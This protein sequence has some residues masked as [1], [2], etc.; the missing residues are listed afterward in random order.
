MTKI[1]I[2]QNRNRQLIGLAAGIAALAGTIVFANLLRAQEAPTPA[3]AAATGGRRARP[4]AQGAATPDFPEANARRG[5]TEKTMFPEVR[6][7]HEMVGGGNN[8]V[9]EAGL[10]ILHEGGNA[11]DAGVAATLAAAVTEE[12]HFSMGGEMPLLIKMKGQPVQVVS[13]VGTAPMKATPEFYK[14]RPLEPWETPD[15]KPVIPAQGILAT[16]TPGMFDGVMLALEKYGTMSYAQVAAPAIELADAFPTT[17]IFAS[18]LKNDESMLRRWP[19]SVSYF[20]INDKLPVPGQVFKQPDLAKTMRAMVAAE[21]SAKGDRVAKIDAVRDYFYRGPVAKKMGAYS[22]ANGGLETY[23]D[24]A[25]FHAEIDTPRSTTF[26]GYEIVKPGFWTQGPVLLEMF[27]LLESYDLKG[28]GHNSPEYLHTLVE[29]AKLAFADRDTYYGDPKFAKVPEELLLSKSYAADRRKL[30]DPAH[31]SMESRPGQIPGYDIHMPSGNVSKVVVNDTTCVDVVDKVG[32][33]YS[34]TPSGAWLPAD[35]VGDTGIAFGS[36][37]QS[38]VT[39]PGHPNL[40]Q[41]GKRPRVTL[42]PTL[43]LKDG[44]PFLAISTPGADNQ[45][46]A[47]LQVILNIIVFNMTPQAAVEAPRFQTDAFY[48]SFAMHEFVPGKLNLESR[49]PQATADKLTALGHIV[50]VTGP[51]T[52][53]SAPIA[54]KLDEDGVLEGGADPRR[55]RF[56]N[57]D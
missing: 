36:R 10:R 23:S 42:S 7:M 41:G 53:A 1:G 19:S 6:S 49:I 9:T 28:M 31:A 5:A 44:K 30:I 24:I 27:N 25:A 56:I 12:D 8:F 48:S 52:N 4:A 55:G 22:E 51:W 16:T 20:F 45:D 32:N 3:P 50:T 29:A 14:N 40:L 54:I 11:V 18:T 37:L 13:G 46:Q 17:E 21:Q 47:L 57:G 35:M 33:V 34:A 15:R 2:S 43:I 38:F 39:Y 26:H